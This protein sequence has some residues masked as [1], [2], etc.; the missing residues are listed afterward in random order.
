MHQDS[1]ETILGKLKESFLRFRD[2]RREEFAFDG[3]EIGVSRHNGGPIEDR[4]SLY[5]SI[6]L[7][8]VMFDE[9]QRAPELFSHDAER[10]NS[11]G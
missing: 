9:F 1:G 2:F 11:L 6:C 7:S 10:R 3:R 8:A 5:S 4:P